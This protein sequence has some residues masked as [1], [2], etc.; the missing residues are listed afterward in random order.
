[1]ALIGY[2]KLA[3]SA[4]L[5]HPITGLT[6]MNWIN[7]IGLGRRPVARSRRSWV[8]DIVGLEPRTLLST[9]DVLSRRD[10]G[11]V[12]GDY[13]NTGL[14]P[15]ETAL[16]PANVNPAA[17]GKLAAIPVDGQV[18]AQ[19]LIDVGVNITVGPAARDS[20]RGFRR[21]GKR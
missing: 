19:V 12:A 3:G 6:K 9:I 7:R 14:D 16:T 15:F 2:A 10:A 8:P 20:H 21:D 18:Y 1:M 13:T 11:P 4:A 5:L 17:F